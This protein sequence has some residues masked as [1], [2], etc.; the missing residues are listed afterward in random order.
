LLPRFRPLFDHGHR[1]LIEY[2]VIRALVQ[3]V[4]RSILKPHQKDQS[5]DG[6][7][8]FPE[9]CPLKWENT[10]RL[11]STTRCGKAVWVFS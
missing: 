4:S 2:Q 3:V 11:L 6:K 9:F 5:N 10:F 7:Y 1:G 8:E